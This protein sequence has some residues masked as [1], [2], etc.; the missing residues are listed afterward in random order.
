M[1]TPKKVLQTVMS[2]KAK[3]A[4]SLFFF[5]FFNRALYADQN[6]LSEYTQTRFSEDSAI[7]VT[8]ANKVIQTRDGYIWI[9][10]YDGLIRFDGQR[11]KVFGRSDGSLP[12]NNIFTLFEDASGDLW[13]GTND[14]GLALYKNGEFSFLTTE[15]GLPSQSIRS[16]A[17]DSS[18]NLYVSTTSGLAYI[19]QSRG[20]MTVT[21]PDGRPILATNIDVSTKDDAWCVL[22]DGSILVIHHGTVISNIPAG[23]FDGSNLHSIFCSGDGS[24]YL[25]SYGG[26]IFVYDPGAD[27]YAGLFTGSRNTANGFYE[28]VAGRIW[29]CSDNGIGFFKDRNFHPV[30][31]ALINNSFENMIEDYEGNYWFSSSRSGVLLLSRAKLKNVFFAYDI[32]DR[33]VNA[34]AKYHGDLYLGTDDGILILGPDG[35][36][37][38]SDLT[39]TLRNTRIRA[40]AVDSED[41]LWIGTYQDFGVVRYKDGKWVSINVSDG[42]VNERVRSL[43]PRA[44]GGVIATTSSGISIV[45]D[46]KVTRNYTV[47][48]GLSTPVIL[49]AVETENGVIYAG[50]DGGGIYRIDGDTVS[51]ITAEDGLSSGVILRMTVDDANG[52][53]WVSTGN[54]VCLLDD[55]GVRRI[56]KLSGYD[57][58]IFDIRVIGEDELW[59]LGSSEV[60]ICG[61]SN[62]LSDDPLRIEAIGKQDGL[63]SPVTANSWNYMSDEGVLHI[64]CTRGIHS[65]DTKNVYKNEIRPKLVI[66]S[67]TIDEEILE[68]PNQEETITV[69]SH[70]RRIIVDF[71]LLSYISSNKNRVSV[72]LEGFDSAPSIFDMSL[73]TSVSYTN[74]AGGKY[75]LRMIGTNAY[76]ISSEEITLRIKKSPK[77]IEMPLTWAVLV[78]ATI[79]FVFFTAKLYGRYKTL[80]KDKLLVGVNKAASL[81]IADIHDDMDYAIWGALKILGESVATKTAFLWRNGCGGDNPKPSRITSWLGEES[82][83]DGSGPMSLDIPIDSLI[84]NWK[85]NSGFGLKSVGLSAEQLSAFGMPGK[86]ISGANYFTAVPILMQE[87]LWGF[88][89]FANHD[90][91]RFFSGEQIDILASGGLLIASAITRSDMIIDFIEAKETALAAARAKSDF[92][93]RM[94]HEIRTPMNAIIGMSELALR[95]DISPLPAAT[96]VS[97]ISQAGHNLLSI[98]NDILDFSKIES[99]LLQIEN[100]PYKIESA[101]ND[102]I[103]VIRTRIAEKHLLFLVEV[104]PGIPC[105]LRGDAARIR[106]ILINLLG[107]AVK[108][109]QEGFVKL[110]VDALS[111][112][113]GSL[114]LSFV[115]SDSGIGIKSEDMKNL[116]GDFVRVDIERNNGVEGTGLGLSISRSL[117]RA[118]GG[119]ISV[120]SVYGKGSEFTVTLPQS[121]DSSEVIAS[122]NDRERRS[123]LM[124]HKRPE[125][126]DSVARTL[127]SLGVVYRRVRES[128]EFLRELEGGGWSHAFVSSTEADA[129]R[130]T[131][132]KNL[133]PTK[134]VL[135]ADIGE[136][137]SPSGV[138]CVML[139]AWA[140][141]VANVLNGVDISMREK[142]LDVRF[143]A[144]RARIL[145]VDDIATNLQVVSG[146]LSPYHVKTD[147]C[148][149]GFDAIKLVTEH[150]YDMVLMDHMMPEM[151]GIETTKRIRKLEGDRFA[152]LPIIA[153]TANA[154]SGM[155][156]KFLQSGFDDYLA[157]PIEISKL[158]DI[159][160]KWT[161][162]EKRVK[163]IALAPKSDAGAVFAQISGVDVARGVAMTG[164]TEKGYVKV[165]ELY[166]RDA[167]ERVKFLR[168]FGERMGDSLPDSSMSL[169]VTQ[170][171]AL[172]SASASIGA[173]EIA[174]DAALLETAGKN[175]DTRAIASTLDAFCDAVSSLVERI[176]KAIPEDIRGEESSI[177]SLSEILPKLK[178][179]LILENV[180]AIDEILAELSKTYTDTFTSESLSKIADCVLISDFRKAVEAVDILLLAASERPMT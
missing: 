120:T 42:L 163:S 22:N 64:S 176:E 104:N 67:V 123:V 111:I 101:L 87:G 18:G 54:G 149:S 100:A 121:S 91:K 159:I 98:I 95:E 11:S 178:D 82:L 156:E 161:P 102:V 130:E 177:D 155:R 24:I 108:Y 122:V 23:Y 126:A 166:C 148:V 39:E 81:L 53:I 21:A 116:F 62:L 77:L 55:S 117:C 78:T 47:E 65:I 43:C 150:E 57:N 118:M 1:M 141:P 49:N 16:I 103:N 151:D 85:S 105:V 32:P 167:A 19:T 154:V 3:L 153:L 145:V 158:N 171:H 80:Q 76:N 9:A 12:T 28:D 31:G 128:S 164:G 131:V 109:T 180:G 135:L 41:N 50:S 157:K 44:G 113:E 70:A 56:D 2:C 144:P 63:T 179:A 40:L 68:N 168:E 169:F 162:E 33:T 173:S 38:A 27:K 138:N 26:R 5:I 35:K 71:A 36:E 114:T 170:A 61:R 132:R 142:S 72:C 88:I 58:S 146:L 172:K 7:P 4:L 75:T 137:F 99:G 15:N 79:A 106:Q 10:S 52:D 107:N 133:L 165:L 112:S 25:G 110:E 129:A 74:L 119:D 90:P 86:I 29:V 14:S 46:D 97:G 69:P 89:S 83:P 60:Y 136:A 124:Y 8:T 127:E 174:R 160:E 139:P 134:V 96:Y 13:I 140:V 143:V 147:T 59:L 6:F 115:I 152:K 93:A 34:I 51:D 92:L 48:D 73:A 37:T 175:R 20:I 17:Q 30:D 66:N 45:R 84:P 94:S 125:Y